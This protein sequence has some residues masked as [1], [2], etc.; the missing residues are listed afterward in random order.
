MEEGA[1][2]A[3][4]T[5]TASQREGGPGAAGEAGGGSRCR[6]LLATARPLLWTALCFGLLLLALLLSGAEAKHIRGA[7]DA[8]VGGKADEPAAATEGGDSPPP[9]LPA[10]VARN[11][12]TSTLPNFPHKVGRVSVPNAE[13]GMTLSRIA[14]GS[15]HFP[16]FEGAWRVFPLLGG[17]GW[18]VGGV[19]VLCTRR[20]LTRRHIFGGMGWDVWDALGWVRGV[21]GAWIR[22]R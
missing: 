19:G 16:E 20:A 10:A 22:L 3:A 2:I 5:A 7:A 12:T 4:T 14:Y 21:G 1:A 15:L 17:V 9:P 6:P 8:A 18:A 13:R 11:K